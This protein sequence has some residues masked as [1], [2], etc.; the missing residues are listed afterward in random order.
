M[1]WLLQKSYFF[2]KNWI[3]EAGYQILK[4]GYVLCI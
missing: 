2:R 3:L 4:A 1:V